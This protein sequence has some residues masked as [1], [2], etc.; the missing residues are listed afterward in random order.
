MNSERGRRF[1]IVVVR[2]VEAGAVVAVEDSCRWARWLLVGLKEVWAGH[3][4]I[5]CF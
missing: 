2:E 4:R 3:D 5:D 1:V